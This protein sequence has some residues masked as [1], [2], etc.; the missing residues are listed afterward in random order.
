VIS[1][2]RPSVVGWGC[3]LHARRWT[4]CKRRS[5]CIPR[6]IAAGEQR[7]RPAE[8]TLWP[9]KTCLC[10]ISRPATQTQSTLPRRNG[11]HAQF[12]LDEERGRPAGAR[13]RRARTGP[14]GSHVHTEKICMYLGQEGPKGEPHTARRLYRLADGYTSVGW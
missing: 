8:H 12:R 5:S 1:C 13:R 9:P 6:L 2:V 7:N 4:G 10:T 14:A 11:R 3:Y